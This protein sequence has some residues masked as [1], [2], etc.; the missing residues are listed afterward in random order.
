M[1]N[2]EELHR[3]LSDVWGHDLAIG[4]M[5]H[6]LRTTACPAIPALVDAAQHGLDLRLAR[7]VVRCGYCRLSIRA[8]WSA[9][10]E[11][12][13][14]WAAAGRAAQALQT[15]EFTSTDMNRSVHALLSAGPRMAQMRSPSDMRARIADI[16]G[17]L[18]D[19]LDDH[20]PSTSDDLRRIGYA[21]ANTGPSGPAGHS[22]TGFTERA[23]VLAAQLAA[24]VQDEGDLRGAHELYVSVGERARAGECL[25]Q[26][27][28]QLRAQGR[29][30]EALVA[31]AEAWLELE[32]ESGS[33]AL[34]ELGRLAAT[35]GDIHGALALLGTASQG[36]YAVGDQETA[37]RLHDERE[38]LGER[39]PR[40]HRRGGSEGPDTGLST[41][42]ANDQKGTR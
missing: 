8:A 7:H 2:D 21:V 30:E 5:Q 9:H 39:P 10:D 15:G 17:I 12:G 22:R 42:Q 34:A 35:M 3:I 1:M 26:M 14:E 19:Y 4:M 29:H 28:V 27:G 18:A 33:K 23:A 11:L 25:L 24:K 16:A 41:S 20:D 13:N 40:R 37:S 38:L 32:G 31:L 36:Y 6:R